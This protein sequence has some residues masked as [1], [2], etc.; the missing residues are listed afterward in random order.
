MPIGSHKNKFIFRSQNLLIFFKNIRKTKFHEF[1]EFWGDFRKFILRN[2]ELRSHTKAYTRNFFR[3]CHFQKVCMLQA[4]VSTN[5]IKFRV[6]PIIKLLYSQKFIWLNF[7]LLGIRVSTSKQN[8]KNSQFSPNKV[9]FE[10]MNIS[11]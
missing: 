9:S 11:L 7:F 8:F 1:P 10:K 5:I 3:F 6:L 4:S 2:K